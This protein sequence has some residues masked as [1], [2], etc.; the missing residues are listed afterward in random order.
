MSTNDPA[1]R[2]VRVER[3]IYRRSSG[4]YEIGFK[5]AQNKQRWRTVAGGISAARAARDELLA[6]RHR[7]E[8]VES[9]RRL[10]FADAAKHG[11]RDRF[12]IS[13]LARASAIEMP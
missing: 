5:D 10:R 12:R 3:N 1:P 2:R 8:Q 11:L 9:Q 4:V 7:G 13:A 6:K